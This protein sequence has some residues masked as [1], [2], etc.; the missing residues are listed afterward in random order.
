MCII[1]CY[2]PLIQMSHFQLR[3]P[4]IRKSQFKSILFHLNC[5]FNSQTTCW[6]GLKNSGKKM[7]FCGSA[8]SNEEKVILINFSSKI[9]ATVTKCWTSNVTH[10]IAATEANGACSRTMK[11]LRAILNGRWI[12]N[13]EWN[14]CWHIGHGS[15]SI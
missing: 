15:T 1:S 8:L 9:R 11:V 12:L 3:T 2:V 4:V 7:V 10:A 6:G 14:C 13:E 5:H